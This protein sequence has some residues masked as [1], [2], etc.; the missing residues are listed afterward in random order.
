MDKLGSLS[1]ASSRN[2][3]SSKTSIYTAPLCLTLPYKTKMQSYQNLVIQGNSWPQCVL[4]LVRL[5][6]PIACLKAVLNLKLG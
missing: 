2:S 4:S 3:N 6:V 1:L 5:V